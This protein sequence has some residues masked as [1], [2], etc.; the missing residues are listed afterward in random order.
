MRYIP[1]GLGEKMEDWV[2][3][4]HQIGA[5]ARRRFRTTK[6]LAMRAKA[7]AKAEQRSINADLIDRQNVVKQEHARK[8]RE[9]GTT[10]ED[11]RQKIREQLRFFA[12]VGYQM[13][14]GRA[15]CIVRRAIMKWV[16]KRRQMS[17]SRHDVMG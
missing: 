13:G 9:D 7:R 17:E 1:G 5:R 2:E 14:R 10:M 16:L 15:L 11:E 8:P 4:M 6:D 12:L 3:L